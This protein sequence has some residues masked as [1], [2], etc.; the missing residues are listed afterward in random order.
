MIWSTGA[1]ASD[2]LGQLQ[3]ATDEKGFLVTHPT[4]QSI[5]TPH[6]FAVGDAGTISTSP[7]P[8][9]G[10]YAVRQGPI[11]WENIQRSLV[12]APLVHYRPQRS[13]LQLL[14]TGDVKECGHWKRFAMSNLWLMAG[15][16]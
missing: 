1:G 11:L 8:K 9:A 5:T 6:V 7:T 13:F 10:V 12:D 14:N 15:K 16:K 3:L 4:L 2:F